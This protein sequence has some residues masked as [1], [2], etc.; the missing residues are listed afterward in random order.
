ML[1][2]VPSLYHL[3][4]SLYH[5]TAGYLFYDQDGKEISKTES[6]HLCRKLHPS[7]K[8]RTKVRSIITG[9]SAKEPESTPEPKT[10][11]EH[12]TGLAPAAQQ[13]DS[14]VNDTVQSCSM[15]SAP[16]G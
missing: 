6:W 12:G 15:N 3:V 14:M 10:G 7:P 2:L 9:A 11:S 4:P 1:N 13:L 8:Q 5:Y 16:G